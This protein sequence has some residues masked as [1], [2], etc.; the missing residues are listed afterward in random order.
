MIADS[1][2]FKSN[3]VS[4]SLEGLNP[5]HSPEAEQAVLGA[6]LSGNEEVVDLATEKLQPKD[7]FHPG[8]EILFDA[9]G[10]MRSASLPI[11]PGTVFQYLEDRKLADA[12]GGGAALLGELATSVLSTLTAPTHID[13]VRSKSLLR[14]L[15]KSCAEIVYSAQERQHEVDAVIDEA[16]QSIFKIAEKG[17]S[18]SH[19]ESKDV[20]IS[21][22][23]MIENRMKRKGMYDGLP[24]GFDELDQL[25]TG[26]KPGEMI[27]VAARPGVGK[28]AFA[29]SMAKN[30]LKSRYDEVQERMVMPGYPVAMFSLEMTSEQMMLRLLASCANVRLQAI[31]DGTLNQ[32]DID[33]L[34]KVGEDLANY[35]LYVDESSMLNITQLRA[36]AR[37]LKQ[38]HDIQVIII[39]YL[40]LLTSNSEKAKNN[41]QVEV[42]EI[43]RGIKALALE[44][45]IP[46]I[47]LA[48]LNRKPEEGNQ[49]PALHHLRESGSIEQDADVVMMLSRS[50]TK[51]GEAEAIDNQH[52]RALKASVNVVKQR[53]GPTD[54]V[55]L[56]FQADYTRFDSWPRTAK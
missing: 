28:T 44:L 43:S 54:K 56:L 29:L 12:I 52:G 32:Q 25:T 19:R 37:R 46:I 4:I 18:Q 49:E 15:Q 3:Q 27:V 42:A 9:M 23:E 36:K 21:T 35:P 30:F 48:Q 50:F 38:H 17:T 33:L 31:R 24:S 53:N 1:T 55:D 22:I 26:F 39:D 16:E 40:Q 7:F 13:T 45:K 6:M 34:M 5:I 11:D 47:V 10:Q 51:D 8:H 14:Q 2:R 20:V 41:R